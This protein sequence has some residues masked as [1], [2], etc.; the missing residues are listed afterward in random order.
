MNNTVIQTAERFGEAIIRGDFSA[1]HA[2]LTPEAQQAHSPDKLKSAVAEML[3]YAEEPLKRASVVP[4]A[5]LTDWPGKRPGDVAWI[6]VAL[7]G[8]SYSEAVSVVITDTPH[9][10]RIRALEWGRP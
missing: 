10:A 1:A 3:T 8:D 2:L 6:Y 9:G 4:E 5:T 7:E